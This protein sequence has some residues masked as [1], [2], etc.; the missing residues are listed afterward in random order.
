MSSREPLWFCHQCN[1]EMRPIMAPHPICA[2]CRGEFVEKMENPADD[3][4]EFLHGDAGDLN[5]PGSLD[6][7]LAGLHGM[8]EHT[9]RSRPRQS[10]E[11]DGGSRITFQILNDE[12]RRTVSFGGRNTLG[13]RSSQGSQGHVP[14]MSEYLRRDTPTSSSIAGPLMMHYIM[15]LLGHND[16]TFDMFS[17]MGAEGGRMGDYVFNQ[18]DLDQI[19]T[20]LMEGANTNRPVPASEEII[21][22]LKRD[23]LLEGSDTL[24]KD[25]AIC[26]EQF[27]LQTENPDEFMVVTL[28]CN[29]IFHEPC[30][31]PW[32]KASGTCPVCRDALVPQPGDPSTSRSGGNAR[33]RSP[34]SNSNSRSRSPGTSQ[35]QPGLFQS[36]LGGF[37]R[38]NDSSSH[39]RSNSDPSRSHDC[40]PGGWEEGLD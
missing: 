33:P 23:V 11:S 1:A 22:N 4:R 39:R 27:S 29:H 30:I 7:F 16:P 36:F 21:N 19:I 15:A 3:P 5:L 35:R 13:R 28:P 24:G 38:P 31:I 2:S 37:N 14:T 12:G 10:S 20:Q 32:L 17:H 8:S 25:C 18:E 34:S 40:F 26:K 6:A 9:N